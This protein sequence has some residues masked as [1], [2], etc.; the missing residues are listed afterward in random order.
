[1][2]QHATASGEMED[3]LVCKDP[4]AAARAAGRPFRK[5]AQARAGAVACKAYTDHEEETR[6]KTAT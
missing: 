1:M 4:G 6:L 5:E 3:R 2:T